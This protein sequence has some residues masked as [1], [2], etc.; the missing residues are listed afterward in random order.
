MTWSHYNSAESTLPDCDCDLYIFAAGS[1]RFYII[2]LIT[3]G[4]IFLEC[5]RG[6]EMTCSGFKNLEAVYVAKLSW[7]WL[8][9]C[10]AI[11]EKKNSQQP[12]RVYN[13]PSVTPV[14]T[15]WS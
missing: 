5:L 2:H 13:E 7:Y 9:R 15:P 1:S 14:Y 12:L 4:I 3:T 10:N 11:R 6:S 8:K